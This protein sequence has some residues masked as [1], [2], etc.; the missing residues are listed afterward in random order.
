MNEQTGTHTLAEAQLRRQSRLA[1]T[2]NTDDQ[3]K[4]YAHDDDEYLEDEPRSHTSVRAYKPANTKPQA[5]I[6]TTTHRTPVPPRASASYSQPGPQPVTQPP[7]A[8]PRVVRTP[9]PTHSH[10]T[11]RRVQLHPLLYIGLAMLL[12]ICGWVILSAL[13]AWF[14]VKQDDWTYG[15]PRTYQID[16]VVGHHDSAA[17]PSH[18]VVMNFRGRIVVVEFPGGDITKTQVYPGPLIDGKENDLAPVTISFKDVNGDGKP[19]MIVNT[20]MTR[21]VL[22]NDGN[23]FRAAKEGDT[24]KL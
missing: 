3:T 12:M 1:S 8:P 21:F 16:A 7:V 15:R 2:V 22:I 19:D 18:F 24:I 23:S 4:R 5:R 14:Q 6:Q 17:N 9:V 13:G 10:Y 20:P 11:R